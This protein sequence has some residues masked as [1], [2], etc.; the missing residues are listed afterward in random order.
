MGNRQTH[1]KILKMDS[2][3]KI[4]N[5]LY[6]NHKSRPEIDKVILS[7]LEANDI[8]RVSASIRTFVVAKSARY[9]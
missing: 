4:G 7:L 5:L 2:S 8:E 3:D 9:V 6:L 1:E